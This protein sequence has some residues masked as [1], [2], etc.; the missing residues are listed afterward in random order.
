MHCILSKITDGAFEIHAGCWLVLSSI[1]IS[2]S[3]V[4]FCLIIAV[5]HGVIW[6]LS[7]LPVISYFWYWFFCQK[8]RAFS[9]VWHLKL[10]VILLF[11]SV[12]L[13]CVCAL[14]GPALIVLNGGAEHLLVFRSRALCRLITTLFHRIKR[15]SLRPCR[16]TSLLVDLTLTQEEVCSPA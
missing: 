16:I 13:F 12:F 1:K 10:S 8:S 5:L 9:S 4:E 14:G 6:L 2:K 7:L 15:L 11:Q 3:Q